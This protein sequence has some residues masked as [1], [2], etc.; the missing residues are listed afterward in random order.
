MRCLRI[1]KKLKC[2][3]CDFTTCKVLK[4]N[5]MSSDTVYTKKE[6]HYVTYGKQ[7]RG[8]DFVESSQKLAIGKSGKEE[9]GSD[10]EICFLLMN[11]SK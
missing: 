9:S 10:S 5:E 8:C 3:Y 1:T 2:F 7:K 4:I 11:L 6:I